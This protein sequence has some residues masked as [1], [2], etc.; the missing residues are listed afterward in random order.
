MML[1]GMTITDPIN[2]MITITK[3]IISIQ[4]IIL[5]GIWDLFNLVQ[6]DSLNRMIPLI[7]I[8]LS[9][10]CS[11]LNHK[12]L[13]SNLNSESLLSFTATDNNSQPFDTHVHPNKK[14]C[15]QKIYETWKPIHMTELLYFFLLCWSTDN[16]ENCFNLN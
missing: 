10:T 5:R 7:V 11:I 2:Q 15:A 12:Y 6:F 1:S 13:I 14:W 4:S 3:Y 8:P 9:S 16:T